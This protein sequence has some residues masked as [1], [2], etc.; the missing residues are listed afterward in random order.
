M[1]L[2]FHSNSSKNILKVDHLFNSQSISLMLGVSLLSQVEFF[3]YFLMKRKIII[4]E[5]VIEDWKFRTLSSYTALFHSC[6]NKPLIMTLDIPQIE[7]LS[8]LH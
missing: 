2:E 7:A 8:V 1:L 3:N 6:S 5:Q 4:L